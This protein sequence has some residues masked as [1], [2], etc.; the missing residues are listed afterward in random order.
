[1]IIL[2]NDDKRVLECKGNFNVI[3]TLVDHLQL[4]LRFCDDGEFLNLKNYWG[5]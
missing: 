2:S 5:I 1:M 4:E 3:S